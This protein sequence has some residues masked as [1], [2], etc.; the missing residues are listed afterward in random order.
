MTTEKKLYKEE[1]YKC[2]GSGHLSYYGHVANG[3]CFACNGSGYHY[4]KTSPEVRQKARER[5]QAKREAEAKKAREEAEAKRQ[6]IR[7]KWNARHEDNEAVFTFLQENYDKGNAFIHEMHLRLQND[8]RLS[9]GQT[10]AIRKMIARKEQASKSEFVGTLNERRDFT[11]TIN[12]IISFDGYYGEVFIHLMNEGDNI[13]V[14]KGSAILGEEGE[15]VNV[16]ATIKD[17]EIR[18]GGVNQTIINR[19]KVQ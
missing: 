14:Y 9:D 5:A 7:D 10:D 15:T 18:E 1:C 8:G 11:L 17:Y 12:K 3:V 16:K 4:Y 6:V 13:V 19:P 2:H